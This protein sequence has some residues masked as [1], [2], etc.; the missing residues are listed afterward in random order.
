MKV[1]Q[2]SNLVSEFARAAAEIVAKLGGRTL[3]G[4]VDLFSSF[5]CWVM[6]VR[7]A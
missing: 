7:G 3:A 5:Q 6:E 2:N 4:T 1:S